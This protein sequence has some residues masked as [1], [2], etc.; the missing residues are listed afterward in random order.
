MIIVSVLLVTTN[1]QAQTP[2]ELFNEAFPKLGNELKCS[3]EKTSLNAQEIADFRTELGRLSDANDDL[4]AHEVGALTDENFK[5]FTKKMLKKADTKALAVLLA[6]KRK[7][8]IAYM[9]TKAK[10]GADDAECKKTIALYEQA[11]KQKSYDDAYNHWGVLF[12]F[13]P[14]SRKSI[15]SKA[16][17][18]F[19]Y[20]YNKA[21]K[22]EKSAW[23]DTLMIVYDQRIK[24]FGKSKKY[25]KGY[26]LGRKGKDLLKYRKDDFEKAFGYL[27]ESVQLRGVNS[28][29]AV[30]LT[31]M[32]VTEGMFVNE[33]I[34]ADV[35]VDTYSQLSDLLVKKLPLT[36]DKNKTQQAIDGVDDIFSHSKAATCEGIIGAYDKKFKANPTDVELLEKI[37]KILDDKDCTDSPLFFDVAVKLNE[38][39]PSAFASY[40]IANMSLKKKEYEKAGEFLNKAIELETN[41]SLKAKYYFKLAQATNEMGQKVK[42]RSYANKAIGLRKDYG[43][44]YVL[45]ATLYASSGCKQLTKP[46]AEMPRVNYWV[47][48]DKLIQAKNADPSIADQA[49]KLIGMYS[50]NYPNKE[51]AFFYGVTKGTPV[52]VG[53]WI[54]EST[55]ARF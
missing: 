15:Y 47:A 27:K 49:S 44:P 19:T 31:Y 53:C 45:I 33:K 18:L 22:E 52:I 4:V 28:E 2:Q 5:I 34:G 38:L 46:E 8:I 54:N 6:E 35:V 48:V 29:D 26:I 51:D 20:K 21:S 25:G 42:A 1:L 43:A 9:G 13:Y 41:D 10:Y 40:S 24:Y 55:K 12:H 32:Q 30:I 3:D 37:A 7:A 17:T 39:K 36:K 23:V 11:M 16:S 50:R 14:M